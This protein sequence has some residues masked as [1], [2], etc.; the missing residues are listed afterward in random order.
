MPSEPSA[1]M[2]EAANAI[3]V[4]LCEPGCIEQQCIDY[5]V[6]ASECIDAA[7]A[8]ER[9]KVER[10][11]ERSALALRHLR[12]ECACVA[13]GDARTICGCVWPLEQALAAFEEN[14]SSLLTLEEINDCN[15]AMTRNE[16]EATPPAV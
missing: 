8:A 4:A 16:K 9:A 13:D 6:E 11:R 12:G 5:M 3:H 2:V 7:Y 15:E 1:W 10:L 14:P